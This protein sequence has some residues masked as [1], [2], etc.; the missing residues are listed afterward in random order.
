MQA[1]RFPALHVFFPVLGG[2][3][4]IACGRRKWP[5]AVVYGDGAGGG[6]A[7]GSAQ[8]IPSHFALVLHI[9]PSVATPKKTLPKEE[10]AH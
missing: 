5:E 6:L 3:P 2:L 4:V 9:I 1:Y 7:A 8:Q 10:V